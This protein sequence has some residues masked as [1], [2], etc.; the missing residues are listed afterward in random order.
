VVRPVRLVLLVVVTGAFLLGLA[1]PPARGAAAPSGWVASAPQQLGNTLENVSA[2]SCTSVLSCTAVWAAQ[3]GLETARLSD[4]AWSA[5][6]SIDLT[7]VSFS[8][9][10]M[11]RLSCWTSEDCLVLAA[12]N[13]G[14]SPIYA[15]SEAGGSWSSLTQAPSSSTQYSPNLS[16]VSPGWCEVVSTYVDNSISYYRLDEQTW[17][18]SQGFSPR[19]STGLLNPYDAADVS[20]WAQGECRFLSGTLTA[21]NPSQASDWTSLATTD[22]SH[23][24]SGATLYSMSCWA[25]SGC[26]AVGVSGSGYPITFS[27]NGSLWLQQIFSNLPMGALASVS[28]S[29]GVCA[30]VGTSSSGW[31]VGNNQTGQFVVEAS[32]ALVMG[33]GVSCSGNLECVMLALEPP[34]QFSWI[35]YLPT[36]HAPAHATVSGAVGDPLSLQLGGRV[37]G[38]DGS[39]RFSVVQG[40]LPRGVSLDPATGT[41]SGTPRSAGSSSVVVRIS[42]SG[43]PAQAVDTEVQITV[44]SAPTTTSTPTST[45]TPTTVPRTTSPDSTIDP[46]ELAA[47]GASYPEVGTATL[48]LLAAGWILLLGARRARSTR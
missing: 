35:S 38:G 26:A 6:T 31:T 16:C 48:V 45:S 2:I 37:T 9:N 41:I 47:T 18:P 20:C 11:V 44:T 17:T 1:G 8:G 7:G 40:S 19:T 21:V 43:P 10:G 34:Y 32:T 42:S 13:G 46:R 4:G 14:S 22:P 12:T 30:T 24:D 27:L 5:P 15:A 25:E 33:L 28:C 39:Y 23:F 29:S 36:L 3:T